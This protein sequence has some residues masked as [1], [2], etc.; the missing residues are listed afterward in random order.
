MI[1][2]LIVGLA[3]AGTG[4]VVLW[5]VFRSFGEQRPG[6]S[7]HIGLMAALVAFVFAVCAVLLLL[8]YR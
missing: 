3:V 6:R 7:S 2:V 1:V 8:A 5:F 4:T